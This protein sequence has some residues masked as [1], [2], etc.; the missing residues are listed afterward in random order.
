MHLP[1]LHQACRPQEERHAQAHLPPPEVS[2]AAPLA[3]YPQVEATC[4]GNTLYSTQVKAMFQASMART[5]MVASLAGDMVPHTG[6]AMATAT[7]TAVATVVSTVVAS[8][9]VSV[10]SAMAS[11][12]QAMAAL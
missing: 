12:V 7:T 3:K 8:P 5:P 4:L 10:N 6:V 2:L 9:L 11:A 1:A